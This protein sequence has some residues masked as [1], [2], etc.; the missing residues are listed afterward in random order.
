MPVLFRDYETR[1]RRWLGKAKGAVNAWRYAADDSTE[2]L[3]CSYAVDSGDVGLWSPDQAIPEAFVT[4]AADPSWLVVAHNDEFDSAIETYLLAPKYGWPIVPPDRHRCTMALARAN[5]LPGSLEGAGAALGL[6]FQKDKAG[7]ITMRKIARYQ[8]EPTPAQL[9]QLGEYCK[10]DTRVARELFNT[11][12]PLTDDEQAVWR[13]DRVINARGFPIDRE[14]ALAVAALG[15]KQRTAVDVAIVGLTGG[16]VRTVNSRDQALKWLAG[17]GCE[18][19]DLNKETVA[20]VLMNGLAPDARRFLELRQDGARA[21]ANKLDTLLACLD[22]DDRLRGALVYHGAAPGRWSG[23]KFQPQN[24]KRPDKATDLDA[25]IATI[26]QG[27]SMPLSVAA[28]VSRSLIRAKP[29][30]VLIGADYSAIESRVLAWLSDEQWKINNYRR[31]DETGDPDLE[32]YCVTASRLLGRK[33]TPADEAGRRIGKTADLALGF[34]GG[35]GAWRKANKA[36]TRGDAEI[37]AD[38]G[39]WRRAH[40]KITAF[41]R[42]L[43][44][45][46][47][48]AVKH[49]GQTFIA[50]PIAAQSDDIGTLEVTLPSKRQ[51]IY[52]EAKVVAGRYEDSFE[53]QYRSSKKGWKPIAEWYGKFTENCVQAVARDLL[54]AA[55]LRIEAADF[56]IILHVHD[57]IVA[58]IPEGADRRA[59]FV[60]LMTALPDWAAGLPVAA[61]AWCGLRYDKSHK[62][63]AG[64][65]EQEDDADDAETVEPE[66]A[67][68]EQAAAN[69]SPGEEPRKRYADH[70][71]DAG[72]PYAPVRAGLLERGYKLAKSFPFT[73]PGEAEPL[74]FEDRYE[75]SAKNG[76][77]RPKECRFRHIRNGVEMCDTG[78]RRILYGVPGLT[79]AGLGVPVFI[80]EGAAKCDPLIAAGLVAVAAPYHTFKDECATAL[81]G[82]NLIYL[83]DHDLPDKGGRIAAKE[84]SERAQR[85]LLGLAASFRIVPAASLWKNLGSAG[86]PPHGWDVKDWVAAGGKAALLHEICKAEPDMAAVDPV[87]LWGHFDPPPLPE[88]LLPVV[89]EEFAKEEAGTMGAD[90]TGLAM[91]ALTV[92]AA[93]LPDRVKL[94]VKKHNSHWKESARIWTAVVGGVS[95]KKTPILSRATMAIRKVDWDLARTF[96]TEMEVYGQLTKEE[97]KQHKPPTPVRLVIEDCTIEAMQEAVKGNLDGV[98][99]VHDELAG[100][101]GSMERYNGRAGNSNRAFYLQAY[102][103][104]QYI[105]DRV[106]RGAI[107]F[108]NLSMCVLGGIQPDVMRGIAADSVEDGLIQRIVP[109]MLRDA[110]AGK[111]VPAGRAGAR[112]DQLVASLRETV[113]PPEP[114]QLDDAARAI[115]EGLEHR[116][117]KLQRYYAGFNKRLAAHIGKYDGLFARL[118]LLWHHVEGAGTPAVTESTAQRVAEFMHRFMLPHAIAFYTSILG[119][120]DN[121]DSVSQVAGYILAK[122]LVRITSRDIQSGVAAMSGLK[123]Q[124]VEVICDQLESLGWLF[125]VQGPRRD[126]A[127][128]EVNPEVHRKFA[129]RAAREATAR[130]GRRET[131]MEEAAERRA[132]KGEKG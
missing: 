80:T 87:D 111:D 79:K 121:H 130:A 56:P 47:R 39:K 90:P 66:T 112:Y 52:P 103:G 104:G 44:L 84:F 69:P 88:G 42:E 100:F 50:G 3:C 35:A 116:H 102:N 67:Q 78:P 21:S 32:P 98:L 106:G 26:L 12:P 75:K 61:K 128:W 29:G 4:A 99:K 82:R 40:P 125:R 30:Y 123:R 27:G 109:V 46:L 126:S 17:Q 114:L 53:I 132:Q 68:A 19:P 8:I 83:E 58:E 24:L 122:K 51:I 105:L 107:R 89:I 5:A 25:A 113:P 31:Y 72:K 77:D 97:Q 76:K 85:Q 38:V 71:A 86:E 118:C 55:M 49:P 28:D 65:E 15:T 91:A 10:Q 6:A 63:A 127:H 18:L 120:S 34:G 41:W 22:A 64:G 73:L 96:E 33:V 20:K 92:C 60:A 13:E 7:A 54:A 101:F 93:G 129:E 124:E 115:R 81:A 108:E 62:D 110:E 1:S 74:F 9:A 94:Q 57:E 36:D 117:I 119:V 11:L 95:A 59:E 16:A 14:L 23:S 45:A 2:V 131:I 37:A 48:R 70:G 43:D